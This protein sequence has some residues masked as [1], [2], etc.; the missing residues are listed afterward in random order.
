MTEAHGAIRQL[1]KAAL[2]RPLP[3]RLEASPENVQ[4]AQDFV[5]QRWIDRAQELGKPLPVDMSLGCKFASLFAWQLFGGRL[6]GNY[7]HQHVVTHA[8]EI[9]DLCAGSSELVSISEPYAH[10]PHF[11]G[12][13][14][15]VDS[16][17]SYLPRVSMWLKAW[18]LAHP[19]L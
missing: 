7:L 19:S 1:S 4:L 9:L 16:L 12:N 15:H 13:R 17:N 10:D 8:G 6:K 3:A 14:D 11:F 5:L 2:G 18:G